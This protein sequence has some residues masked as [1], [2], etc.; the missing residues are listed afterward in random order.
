MRRNY[1]LTI[2]SVSAISVSEQDE[3]MYECF[4]NAFTTSG[5]IHNTVNVTT[6]FFHSSDELTVDDIP[7]AEGIGSENVTL[8][9]VS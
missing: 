2:T 8:T 3:I 5:A 6:I 9:E 7:L 4:G 1:K